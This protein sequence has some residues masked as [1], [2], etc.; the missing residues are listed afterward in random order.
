MP[1]STSPFTWEVFI[2]HAFSYLSFH[3]NDDD[4]NNN[5]DNNNNNNNTFEIQWNSFSF[6]I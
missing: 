5:D 1:S 2:T 4:D 3:I 6:S